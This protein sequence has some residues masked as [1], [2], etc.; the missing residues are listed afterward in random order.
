MNG[1]GRSD[2]GQICIYRT[3][4]WN[5]YTEYDG[6]SLVSLVDLHITNMLVPPATAE[7]P[8]THRAS[9]TN[10]KTPNMM[11]TGKT[12]ETFFLLL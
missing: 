11:Q 8:S 7:P 6:I 3:L 12:G 9:R 10:L 1:F 5:F 4:W 2:S